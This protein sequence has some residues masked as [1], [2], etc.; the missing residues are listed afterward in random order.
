[1][2]D[3]KIGLFTAAK[4]SINASL[5]AITGIAATVNSVAEAGVLA[6]SSWVKESAMEQ[7]VESYG[8]SEEQARSL[9]VGLC[10]DLMV[11]AE[12][13]RF[14]RPKEA[15]EA[16]TQLMELVRAAKA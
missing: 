14:S 11:L 3:K 10:K 2:S 12:T 13:G 8:L 6:S 16:R 5:F 15:R 1:M 7:L 4:D 9:D